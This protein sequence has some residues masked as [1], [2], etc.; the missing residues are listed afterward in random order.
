[1]MEAFDGDRLRA[2]TV[3]LWGWEGSA[4][5]EQ[6]GRPRRLPVAT[7]AFLE[8]DRANRLVRLSAARA[9][10]GLACTLVLVA[11]DRNTTV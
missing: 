8:R 1:M 2:T 5:I 4:G 10:L 3:G 9:A 11:G 7:I 6:H